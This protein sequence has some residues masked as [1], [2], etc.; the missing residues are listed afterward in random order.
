MKIGREEITQQQL[1]FLIIAMAASFLVCFGLSKWFGL[2]I[3][4]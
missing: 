3:Q 1:I 2:A 4:R